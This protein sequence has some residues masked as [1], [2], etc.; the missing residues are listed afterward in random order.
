MPSTSGGRGGGGRSIALD[1]AWVPSAGQ[2][3]DRVATGAMWAR[4]NEYGAEPLHVAY[5][6]PGS[7]RALTLRVEGRRPGWR[8]KVGVSVQ[9]TPPGDT[10]A[11]LLFGFGITP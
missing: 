8:W 6:E 4:L 11:G 9:R 1:L 7:L 3:V 10:T 5:P 2:V